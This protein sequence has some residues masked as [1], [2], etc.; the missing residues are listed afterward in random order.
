MPLVHGEALSYSPLLYRAR[1]HWADVR[2]MLVGD[3][4]QPLAV[5]EETPERLD[6]YARILNEAFWFAA[7]RL[8]HAQLDALIVLVSDRGRVF[9]L[10]NTPQ[11]HV[12]A[13]KDIWGDPALAA[14]SETPSPVNV[15]CD[16]D[17][18]TFVGEELASHGFDISESRG[19][20]EPLGDPERGVGPAFIEPVMRL[21]ANAGCRVIPIHVNSH[22]VPAIAGHRMVAFGRALADALALTT[23]RVGILAS[24]GLSGDPNGMLAG[25]IDDVLDRWL[26]ARLATGRSCDLGAIFDIESQ[27]LR[28]ATGEVRL[29]IA[30]GAAMEHAGTLGRLAA[31]IPLHH[32]AV[33]TAFMHWGGS[34]WP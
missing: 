20:F 6:E 24:G 25:W 13:G 15:S 32:A 12:F 11:L 16:A 33:G 4:T 14:L 26:L 30:A 28:G 18:A 3:V 9:D 19:T 2:D 27:G 21:A 7:E 5:R 31:Y 23:K 17:L 10:R 8:A 22:V 1:A 34:R 29:W